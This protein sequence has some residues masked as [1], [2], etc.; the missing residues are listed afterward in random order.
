MQGDSVWLTIMGILIIGS[1]VGLLI[2]K[3]ISPVVGMILIPSIGALLLG[4]GVKDLVK[5][6][7]SGLESV[8]SVVIMFIFAIIFFGIMTDSGLFKP[9]VKRLILMTRGNVVIV[10]IVTALIG[11]FAQLDGAGA[12]TFLLSIPALL[13]L[14]KALN[15][16]KYLLILLLAISAA[17][18]NMV[19]WGGP[20]ARVASV[21]KVK[22]VNELWYGIIPVQLIGF[23]LVLIFA[24][25]LGFREKKRI[26]KAIEKGDL[27]PTLDIDIHRLVKNYERDQD[28]KFPV[29]GRA[30]KHGW[31]IWANVLL[32]V[33]VLVMMLANIAPPEFAFMIG[34]ALA[35]VIN[36]P[37]VD[38]QMNRLKAHA[39]NALMMAAVIIAAGMFLGV[40]EETGMLKAIALSFIKIIPDAV[41]PYLHII[42]GFFGVPLDLLT[43]TDAYYFALLPIVEQTASQFGINPVSTA[44]SMV[45]GNIVGTFVSPFSPA[46]WLAIG[47]AEANMG[48]YIKYAFFWIWGFAI[49]LLAIAVLI[50]TVTI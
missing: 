28:I 32:T 13:P 3:K 14:Y 26:K 30:L 31:V 4:Y 43:S 24:T 10:C 37:N 7:N 11:M 15:M 19:P 18:M 23:V 1:I 35:L 22:S 49:V 47:L 12:V 25:Y 50:G 38:E 20:M 46:L 34:V 8:M 33:I 42:V 17:I 6:F 39:P 2:A 44:Y 27:Q 48:T 45:I 16:N 9:I 29:R 36:F 41:G 40:L 21:L 5:F